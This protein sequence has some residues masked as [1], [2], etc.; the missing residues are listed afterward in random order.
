VA[1]YLDADLIILGTHVVSGFGEFFAG[2]NAFKVVT[3]SPFAVLT[4]QEVRKS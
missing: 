4:I 2:S 3:Q 1:Q